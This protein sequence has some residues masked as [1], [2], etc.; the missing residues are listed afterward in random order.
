MLINNQ[1][2]ELIMVEIKIN[3]PNEVFE[4]I[5]KKVEEGYFNNIEDYILHAIHLLSELYGIGGISILEKILDM[6]MTKTRQ[7]KL[8]E[9]SEDEIYVLSLFRG[10]TFLY[11]EELWARA[12]ED[13]M[14]KGIKPKEKSKIF[15]AVEEL[16][17]KGYLQELKKD[18]EKIIKILKR[19]N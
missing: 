12:L 11:P 3:V 2:G 17:K 13:A 5:K 18:G 19:V 6:W 1:F 7:E 10:S 15:K 8:S 9:L 4:F 14:I 16:V